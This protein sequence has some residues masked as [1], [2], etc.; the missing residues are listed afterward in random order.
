[1][2]VFLFSSKAGI[3]RAEDGIG[4]N[5]PARRAIAGQSLCHC[6]HLDSVWQRTVAA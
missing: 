5:V 2:V 3:H 1:M 6:P 4:D